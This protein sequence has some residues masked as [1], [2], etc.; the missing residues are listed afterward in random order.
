MTKPVFDVIAVDGPA[1]AGKTTASL[2][3]S[4]ELG[5]PYLESGRAY[6]LLAH[7]ALQNGIDIGDPDALLRLCDRQF[8]SDYDLLTGVDGDE[9]SFLRAV[10]VGRA[11]SYVAKVPAVRQIITEATRSWAARS[12]RC[13]IEGRDIGTTVFPNGTAKFYLDATPE[14]RAER[15]L[16]DEP[17]RSYKDVLADVNS[18]DLQD[19][20]RKES[21]LKP[22]ADA[23]II[24]TTKMSKS[25]VL[26]LM[27]KVL[28]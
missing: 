10:D 6:R 15:R 3:I 20:T 7:R 28:L 27:L 14:V 13:I 4:Q 8:V 2:A 21:P 26:H 1:A 24:D 12:G 25:A 11:V 9:L 5:V 18:R 22:A 19:A 17:G 23:L 16:H